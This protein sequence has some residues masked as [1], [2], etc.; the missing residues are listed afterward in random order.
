MS[1][2]QNIKKLAAQY[3]AE[4]I[5]IRRYLHAHPELSFESMKLL[6]LY[7]RNLR[8]TIFLINQEW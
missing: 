1:L 2:K 7:S 4:V 3:H 6:N 5:A 8:N